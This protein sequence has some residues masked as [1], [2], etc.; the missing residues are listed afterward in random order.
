MM[1]ETKIEMPSSQY[2]VCDIPEYEALHPNA[3]AEREGD[4]IRIYIG[5]EQLPLY[6]EDKFSTPE[7]INEG[8]A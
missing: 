3:A 2:A 1:A 5:Q 7:S 8:K 4:S 6:S